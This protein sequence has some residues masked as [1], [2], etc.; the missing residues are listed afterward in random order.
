MH[1]QASDREYQLKMG[2][3]FENELTERR[4]ELSGWSVLWSMQS[5]PRT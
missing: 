5:T 3:C 1:F 4:T 2:W